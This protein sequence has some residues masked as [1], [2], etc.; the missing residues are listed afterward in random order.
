MAE[1]LE[2]GSLAGPDTH[3]A[4]VDPP[5]HAAYTNDQPDPV[6]M[7]DWVGR[8][9]VYADRAHQLIDADNDPSTWGRICATYLREVALT[10]YKTHYEMTAPPRYRRLAH[11]GAF[12]VPLLAVAAGRGLR[13]G[14][15]PFLAA[16]AAASILPGRLAGD[17]ATARHEGRVRRSLWQAIPP[18]PD[19]QEDES[20]PGGSIGALKQEIRAVLANVA[21][22]AAA[23]DH[24]FAGLENTYFGVLAATFKNPQPANASAQIRHLVAA[25]RCV[26]LL[27]TVER[28]LRAKHDEL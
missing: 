4:I 22:S 24:A 13:P 10:A 16:M 25:H 3:D 20:W 26:T 28:M 23:A 19:K 12:V 14:D 27:N 5:S 7:A 11:V 1:H 18:F 21:T 8:C 2:E 17:L 6:P 9:A 15:G